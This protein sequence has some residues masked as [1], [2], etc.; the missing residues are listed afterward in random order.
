MF[1]QL[2][3]MDVIFIRI[4][5]KQH[6]CDLSSRVY[7][8]TMCLCNCKVH[9]CHPKHMNCTNCTFF[10]LEAPQFSLDSV[11]N[12]DTFMIF[13]TA[14]IIYH[15]VCQPSVQ[16]TSSCKAGTG[17]VYDPRVLQVSRPKTCNH[18]SNWKIV[19]WYLLTF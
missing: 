5:S 15:L 16:N 11:N 12:Q 3:S 17:R 9:R 8:H 14:F 13:L 10:S 18:S 19:T 1:N 7:L 6:S 2:T 4:H